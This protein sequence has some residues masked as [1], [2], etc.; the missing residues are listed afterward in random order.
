MSYINSSLIGIVILLKQLLL[1]KMYIEVNNS[2]IN[3]LFI[4]IFNNKVKI[5][6]ILNIVK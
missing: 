5:F 3:F 4:I 2:I 1:Y 6:K